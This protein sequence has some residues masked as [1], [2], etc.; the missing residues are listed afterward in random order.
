MYFIV[1]YSRTP[2]VF[3]ILAE[4]HAAAD[5]RHERA[6]QDG[7][8]AGK[9][10]EHQ[11]QQQHDHHAPSGDAHEQVAVLPHPVVV[12]AVH[13]WRT[14][15]LHDIKPRS[16]LGSWGNTMRDAA[17]NTERWKRHRTPTQ[18]PSTDLEHNEGEED[19]VV[20][21]RVVQHRREADASASPLRWLLAAAAGT[22]AA[23]AVDASR[24]RHRSAGEAGK[25]GWHAER[26]KQRHDWHEQEPEP[27]RRVHAVEPQRAAAPAAE[28][29]ALRAGPDEGEPRADHRAWAPEYVGVEEWVLRV[30]YWPN[31]NGVFGFG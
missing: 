20:Y 6:H 15:R 22:A 3:S 5:A 17:R 4:H 24:G 12:L 14:D 9:P 29:H 7:G 18:D 11:L 13:E 23:A 8:V 16:A 26:G 28:A 19:Q 31:Q 25:V 27:A 2:L 10:Q 30:R 21:E 1:C